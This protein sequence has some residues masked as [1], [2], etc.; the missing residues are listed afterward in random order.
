MADIDWLES[1]QTTIMSQK[2]IITIQFIFFIFLRCWT[3][4]H[5]WWLRIIVSVKIVKIKG[6]VTNYNVCTN[7]QLQAG[8]RKILCDCD[9]RMRIS[10]VS[11]TLHI[12][13]SMYT[14][15][16]RMSVLP[17]YK[18]HVSPQMGKIMLFLKTFLVLFGTKYNFSHFKFYISITNVLNWKAH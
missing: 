5:R 9:E 15:K 2:R 16:Q 18:S 17:L 4:P 14:F 11:K 12:Q 10:A 6:A 8:N 13:W 1:R 7:S 3:L